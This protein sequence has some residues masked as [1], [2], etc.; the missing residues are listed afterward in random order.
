MRSTATC[1]APRAQCCIFTRRMCHGARLRLHVQWVLQR[2][3]EQ[4]GTASS[5]HCTWSVNYPTS[6]AFGMAGVLEYIQDVSS[7]NRK[8]WMYNRFNDRNSKRTKTFQLFPN[9]FPTISQQYQQRWN[10]RIRLEHPHCTVEII[11]LFRRRKI[12]GTSMM[13]STISGFGTRLMVSWHGRCLGLLL[14]SW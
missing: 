13:R 11:L 4:S 3:A 2:V 12:L 8:G 10:L 6:L 7:P 5:F 9:Y 14:W 1:P